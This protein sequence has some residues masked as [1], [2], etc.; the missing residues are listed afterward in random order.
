MRVASFT[1]TIFRPP[2]P[3]PIPIPRR[4]CLAMSM[5]MSNMPSFKIILGSSSM[6]RRQ[7][8]SDM[9][10]HFSIQT[11]D[12]DEKSI[13]K[14][15]PEDLVMAL[16]HAKADAI[17][18]RLQQDPQL[19]L[20]ITADTVVVYKGVVREKP[21]NQEEARTFIKG[22]S[23]DHAAVVG[24]ILVTNLTTGTRKGAW[25]RAEVYFHKI[26][27]EIIDS[28]IEDKI[29]YNVAGGLM[30]EHPLTSP[31]VEAVVGNTDTVMGLSKALTEKLIAEVQ[32]A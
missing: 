1:T 10:Y 3:I 26:P 15:N 5:S 9:G 22:Y 32:Q 23:G 24:S 4:C 29:T 14:D 31:F 28:L 13:R 2:I 8:L 7:I 20:L 30:L 25:E 12:I 16:A 19:T 21:T 27:D 18:S 17:I 11:A 6:A